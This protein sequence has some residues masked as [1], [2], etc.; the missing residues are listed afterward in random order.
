MTHF[1]KMFAYLQTKN[2]N[3]LKTI[4]DTYRCISK[5]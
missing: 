1:L 4:H 3:Y 5:K 2:M